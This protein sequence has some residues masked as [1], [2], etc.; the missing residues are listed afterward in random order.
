V[1]EELL[2]R[3]ESLFRDVLRASNCPQ[4]RQDGK[5]VC[6]SVGM[7]DLLNKDSG[8]TCVAELMW[9]ACERKRTLLPHVKDRL[10]VRFHLRALL[11]ELPAS[12]ERSAVRFFVFSRRVPGADV[13]SLYDAGAR[14]ALISGLKQ[15]AH[16]LFENR[17][18]LGVLTGG[19]ISAGQCGSAPVAQ[20]FL[21]D[22]LLD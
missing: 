14:E 17:Y 4:S 19:A 16:Y 6:C 22:N 10:R 9:Q 12:D 13:K 1:L 18:E 7:Q 15:F 11:G 8:Q 3:F 21:C 2:M 20:R 5:M